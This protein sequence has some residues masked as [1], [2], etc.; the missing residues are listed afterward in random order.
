[1]DS[2]HA[3]LKALGSDAPTPGGGS[4]A[5][6]M[7]ATGAA[8]VEMVCGLTQGN[9]KFRDVESLMT[10]TRDKAA[11]LRV[12]AEALNRDDSVAYDAVIAAYRLPKNTS[13]EK[14]ARAAAIQ[15]A[16]RGAT[17]VPLRCVVAGVEV[18]DLAATIAGS[19]NPRAISDVGA[20]ALAARA[21]TH[22]ASLNVRANLL[23]IK[24]SAYVTMQK[25]AL[26]VLMARAGTTADAVL[27][28]VYQVL[29]G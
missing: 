28:A 23:A 19:V 7:V 1:M 17:E 22:A 13:E 25:T 14:E 9:E 24:D 10:H 12:S 15:N 16:L 21:G 18:L 20:G 11:A 8:L 5:A 4:A 26:D 29:N 2:I 3:W 27:A 6:L